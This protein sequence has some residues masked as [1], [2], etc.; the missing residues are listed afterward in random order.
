MQ[1]TGLQAVVLL[2]KKAG[3]GGDLQS[4]GV[5]WSHVSHGEVLRRDS[6][7]PP[8]CAPEVLPVLWT[9][10]LGVPR[11]LP[12]REHGSTRG[13]AELNAHSRSPS[14]LGGGGGT[15]DWF[16]SFPWSLPGQ[17]FPGGR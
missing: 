7:P 6:W 1:G 14:S 17:G 4:L 15:E 13:A 9:Q 12:P 5:P 2:P 10:I 16:P 11:P 8:S 3:G